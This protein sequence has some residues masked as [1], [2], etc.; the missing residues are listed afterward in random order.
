MHLTLK[1]CLDE[2]RLQ[3]VNPSCTDYFVKIFLYISTET[4]TLRCF[5]TVNRLF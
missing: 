3:T 4:F 2:L 5:K 1:Y